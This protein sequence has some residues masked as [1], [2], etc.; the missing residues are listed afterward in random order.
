MPQRWRA[1]REDHCP[2]SGGRCGDSV[3]G[4]MALGGR[5]SHATVTPCQARAW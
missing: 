3:G 2:S 1:Q 4:E 5:G